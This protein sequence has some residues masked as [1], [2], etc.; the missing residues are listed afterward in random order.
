MKNILLTLALLISFSSFGQD[1]IKQG[2]VIQYYESGK[3]ESKSNY[4]DG[5]LQGEYITYYESGEIK[6][7]KNFK[8]GVLI[9]D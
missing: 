2:L 9:E 6:E 7:T 8:D 3:V 5:Q 1:D 4:V